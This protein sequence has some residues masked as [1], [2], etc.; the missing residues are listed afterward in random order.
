MRDLHGRDLMKGDFLVVTGDIVSNLDLG[1]ALTKHKARRE[2]DKNAIM[3][4]ILREAGNAD[5]QWKKKRRPV[6][7]IDPRANRCLTY[8]E[9]G[10][11][12]DEG[13]RLLL[14]PEFF[15]GHGEIDV[16]EDL[17]DCHI[18][19]C[20]PEVL[21][22]W[23]DN[24]DYQSLRTSFLFGVLKDYELNGK[25]IHTHIVAD[26]YAARAKDLETYVSISKDISGRWI[27]P[28]CPDTNFFKGQSYHLTPQKNCLEDGVTLGRTTSVRGRTI[29]GR[30]TTVGEGTE[31]EASILGRG[32]KIG[33]NVHIHN[34]Y[35]WDKVT[36]LDG[37]TV[38]GSIIASG[39]TIESDCKIESLSLIAAKSIV[40]ASSY[41]AS[42]TFSNPKESDASPSSTPPLSPTLSTS[43]ISTLN[44]TTS[45]LLLS[46][47]AALNPDDPLASPAHPFRRPSFAMPDPT[48]L[49]KTAAAS[50]SAARA[51]RTEATASIL[52]GIQ[53]GDAP[54]TIFLELNG[55]RMSV[56]ASLHAVRESVVGA[57]MRRVHELMRGFATATPIPASTSLGDEATADSDGATKLVSE[58]LTA[59]EAV[60]EVFGAYVSLLERVVLDRGS[61]ATTST[62]AAAAG[63]AGK[64]GSTAS[65][66]EDQID[67]LLEIQKQCL[68]WPPTPLSSTSTSA[69]AIDTS[70]LPASNP[71]P[72]GQPAGRVG[73][74]SGSNSEGPDLLL[75]V[76]KELYD[77]DLVEEE[78]VLQWWEDER[79]NGSA[80]GSG[81]GSA[82]GGGVNQGM[83]DV[84]V[85]VEKFVTFLREAESEEEDNDGE[86]DDED[87][88]EDEE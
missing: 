61:T 56:D 24:F 67:L 29:I 22:Q 13:H 60:R 44:S 54:E 70:I 75:F 53:K 18:D 62:A 33:Q 26:Q 45:S 10:P 46:P 27:F 79:S 42:A 30:S 1:L 57:F 73:G 11:G 32:C 39:A 4:M 51:F 87:Q 25:T 78:G 2:K 49:G 76:A 31:V 12:G 16:R 34:A 65:R 58:T 6:F 20:T 71:A 36:I 9:L 86:E 80:F 41:I 3:T 85:Q 43:S 55:Y 66:K 84:R 48:Q 17:I 35:I 83:R 5:G 74:S 37:S 68:Y 28:Y 63:G 21:G 50:V 19:I 69:S 7:V 72:V 15:S 38:S 8:E 23:S 81:S 47:A 82:S 59:R 14:D 40:P 88:D 52:D 64:A 77:L